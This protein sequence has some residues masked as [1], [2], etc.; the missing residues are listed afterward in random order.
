[1]CP[2]VN[3]QSLL[4]QGGNE[5]DNNEEGEQIVQ[6]SIYNPIVSNFILYTGSGTI[7]PEGGAAIE[8]DKLIGREICF[9]VSFKLSVSCF[10]AFI[11]RTMIGRPQLINLSKEQPGGCLRRRTRLSRYFMTNPGTASFIAH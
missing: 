1:M 4:P 3:S 9:Q 7:T 8:S 5:D 2:V 11:I 10:I 6:E